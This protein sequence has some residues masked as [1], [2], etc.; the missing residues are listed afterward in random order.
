MDTLPAAGFEGRVR[1]LRDAAV[2]FTAD[3]CPFCRRFEPVFEAASA[4]HPGLAFAVADVSDDADPRWDAYGI[5]VVPT[6]LHFVDGTHVDRLDGALGRGIGEA[7]LDR[8]LRA[9]ASQTRGP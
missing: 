8:A 3:W 5:Q 1:A 7:L 4:R 6:V 9:W 2:C